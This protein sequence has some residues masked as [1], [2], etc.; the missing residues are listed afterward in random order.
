MVPYLYIKKIGHSTLYR[1]YQKLPLVMTSE[2][3]KRDYATITTCKAVVALA[4]I[5]HSG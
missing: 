5:E 3:A 2:K 4:A 1:T